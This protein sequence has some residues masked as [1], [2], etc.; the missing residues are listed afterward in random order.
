LKK[1]NKI[2]SNILSKFFKRQNLMATNDSKNRGFYGL[3]FKKNPQNSTHPDFYKPVD[4]LKRAA[5]W[6]GL[7]LVRIP[8]FTI[9]AAL[10]TPCIIV[11][12]VYYTIVDGIPRKMSGLTFFKSADPRPPDSAYMHGHGS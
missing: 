10:A 2:I 3:L 11:Y 7:T 8:V 1:E 4:S 6:S 9:I 12:G 5:A